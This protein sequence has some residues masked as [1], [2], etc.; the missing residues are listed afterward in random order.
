[1]VRRWPV[2]FRRG[3]PVCWG[4]QLLVG[5]GAS[6][7]CRGMFGVLVWF[8]VVGGRPRLQ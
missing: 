4:V 6:A 2:G 1:M 7:E 5:C 8:G 3:G